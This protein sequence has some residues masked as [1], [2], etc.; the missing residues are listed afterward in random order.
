MERKSNS[1]GVTLTGWK[2][3]KANKKAL[4]Q[5]QK[6]WQK[7]QEQAKKDAAKR[8][9]ERQKAVQQKKDAWNTL[10]GK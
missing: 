8:Q 1:D 5:K 9:Q 2:Y 6:D 3:N 7:Q 10:I 4:E